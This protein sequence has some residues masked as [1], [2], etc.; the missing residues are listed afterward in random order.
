MRGDGRYSRARAHASRLRKIGRYSRCVYQKLKFER[1]DDAARR[2]K[3]VIRCV[4]SAEP[5][6]ETGASLPKERCV[7]EL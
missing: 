7:L 5:G 6:V 1:I 3:C 2:R 4:Q